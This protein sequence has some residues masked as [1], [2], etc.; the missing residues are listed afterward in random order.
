VGGAVTGRALEDSWTVASIVAATANVV[1]VD[2]RFAADGAG[3]EVFAE[4][5][6]AVTDAVSLST[7]GRRDDD[8][9][10]EAGVAE[11]VASSRDLFGF[12]D[13][14]TRSARSRPVLPVEVCAPPE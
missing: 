8:S 14:V 9:A 11:A 13:P 6:N 12:F 5:E 7:D 3:E 2:D 1:G 10:V 4:D